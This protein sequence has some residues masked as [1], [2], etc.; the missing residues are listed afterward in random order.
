MPHMH[1]QKE[2]FSS[3][4]MITEGPLEPRMYGCYLESITKELKEMEGAPH[5]KAFV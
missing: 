4:L 1:S 3:I 5:V 2:R